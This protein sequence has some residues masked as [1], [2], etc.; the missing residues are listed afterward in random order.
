[1]CCRR[2]GDFQGKPKL[3]EMFSMLKNTI[4]FDGGSN[5]VAKHFRLVRL[6]GSAGPEMVWKIYDARRIDDNKV[7]NIVIY[8]ARMLY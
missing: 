7:T 4:N 2:K 5:P 6:V 1:M 8:L 3:M